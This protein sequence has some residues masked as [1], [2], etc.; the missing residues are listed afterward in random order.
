MLL[1]ISKNLRAK[2]PNFFLKCFA[3]VGVALNAHHT[4]DFVGVHILFH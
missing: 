2:T 4:H 3:K 1:M